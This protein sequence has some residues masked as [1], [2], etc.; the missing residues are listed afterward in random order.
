MDDFIVSQLPDLTDFTL[1]EL[2][3]PPPGLRAALDAA[4][5][6]VVQQ[7]LDQSAD[8]GCC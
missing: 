7:V 3:D 5:D 8:G 4:T 6:L 1:A 2:L